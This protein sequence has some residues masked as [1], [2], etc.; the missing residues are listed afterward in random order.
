MRSNWGLMCH[1]LKRLIDIIVYDIW[2][3]YYEVSS[4]VGIILQ[5]LFLYHQGVCNRSFLRG[6]SGQKVN[7][8]YRK[9]TLL[10]PGN[11]K[12]GQT[13]R[14]VTS[15]WI[16]SLHGWSTGLHLY[17]KFFHFYAVILFFMSI[18]NWRHPSNNTC[19]FATLSGHR[20]NKTPE[21]YF[22]Q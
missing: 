16:S 18:E 10:S 8:N 11:R 3:F 14:T 2:L 13:S 9:C 20:L 1:S 19:P 12:S 6:S 4:V 7:Y 5:F 15:T 17:T 22:C 21:I